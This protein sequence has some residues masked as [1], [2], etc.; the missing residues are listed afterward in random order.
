LVLL[1]LLVLLAWPHTGATA[2]QSMAVSAANESKRIPRMD[3][4]SFLKRP[5]LRLTILLWPDVATIFA[6]AYGNG[7]ERM[8]YRNVPAPLVHLAARAG[9]S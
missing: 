8:I 5:P 4:F 9:T 7:A 1:V 2:A 3:D 6:A